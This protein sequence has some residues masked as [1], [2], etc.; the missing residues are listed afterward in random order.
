MSAVEESFF[1]HTCTEKKNITASL[2]ADNQNYF[3]NSGINT[4]SFWHLKYLVAFAV[5]FVRM[6]E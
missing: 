2:N 6:V 3:E 4:D 1:T 5:V